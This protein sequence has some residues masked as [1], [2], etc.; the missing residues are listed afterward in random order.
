MTQEKNEKRDSAIFLKK[1]HGGLT[2]PHFRF[3]LIFLIDSN[4][5]QFLLLQF[6][7]YSF[8]Q[9]YS[10][11]GSKR[12]NK[13]LFSNCS[14]CSSLRI[15]DIKNYFNIYWANL[16]SFKWNQARLHSFS[17]SWLIPQE[18]FQ[19]LSSLKTDS[20]DLFRLF[21]K[22]QEFFMKLI[23]QSKIMTSIHI[24]FFKFS[25]QYIINL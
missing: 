14:N 2:R 8:L 15:I 22:S 21:G 7:F 10:T 24:H 1:K 5:I 16:L 9:S 19:S 11:Y 17:I 4:S 3:F 6:Q 13:H 25:N 23:N 12:T 20:I 18:N